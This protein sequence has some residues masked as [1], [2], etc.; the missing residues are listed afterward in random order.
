MASYLTPE[1]DSVPEM[2]PLADLSLHLAS[3]RYLGLLPLY[4]IQEFASA[5][6]VCHY[7][8]P[9]DSYWAQKI[10]P[11]DLS[12]FLCYNCAKLTGGSAWWSPASGLMV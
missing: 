10:W 11:C 1:T 6:N 8:V 12:L 5:V 3:I 2:G 7:A 9:Y 4:F